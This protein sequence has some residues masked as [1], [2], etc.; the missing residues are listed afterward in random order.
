MMTFNNDA[1][2]LTVEGYSFISEKCYPLFQTIDS[3][4]GIVREATSSMHV[5]MRH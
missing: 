4:G 2:L 5:H 1:L 3:P